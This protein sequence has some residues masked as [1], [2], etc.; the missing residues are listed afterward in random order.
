M[1]TSAALVISD[2]GSGGAQK[3]AVGLAA[4]L[5]SQGI[6]VSVITLDSPESDF[7]FLPANIQRF[8]LNEKNPSGSVWR[9]VSKNVNRILK[10]RKAI[11][12]SNSE[13][14]LSFV[15]PT[16]ILTIL[17][18]IGLN[19]RVVISE[20]NDPARQ[21]FG[22]IWDIL[23]HA[24]YGFAHAVTCNSQSAIKALRA[25]VSESKLHYIPNY[26]PAVNLVYLVQDHL[27]PKIILAV[28]RLHQQ[29]GFD[30]LLNAFLQ[31]HQSAP[32]WRL[33]ILGKGPL[34]KNLK[35]QAMSLGLSKS[36]EFKGVV[37]NPYEFYA[38]SRIFV[39]SSRHEGTPNALLEAMSCG[40]PSIV[41]DSCEGALAYVNHGRSGLVFENE[42]ADN[43]SKKIMQLIENESLR[44]EYAA[45]GQCAVQELHDADYIYKKW[46]S[47]LF[48]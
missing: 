16:N 22:H 31:V 39:L 30:I 19:K 37:E 25:Y 5:V 46:L 4:Y 36:V 13:T 47:V 23:R 29:K 17:A 34:E 27:K 21:S 3:V 7:H 32:D 15:G 45:A 35:T 33:V 10:L 43:L 20:R 9:A 38:Q 2:L 6:K 24:L 40:V 28:G 41:S 48:S 8:A 18:T 42:N 14:V 26:L 1:N 44:K 11:I 12:N